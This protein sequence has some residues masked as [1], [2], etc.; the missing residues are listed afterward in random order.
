M[1]GIGVLVGSVV[2][3]VPAVSAFAGVSVLP[4]VGPP[5]PV[6]TTLSLPTATTL[7]LGSMP[8]VSFGLPAVI[9]LA[10][11]SMAPVGNFSLPADTTGVPAGSVAVP[12]GNFGPAGTTWV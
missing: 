6:D 12:V 2:L 7:V 4:G 8:S 10:W 3:V 1:C 5:V 9:T 11:G